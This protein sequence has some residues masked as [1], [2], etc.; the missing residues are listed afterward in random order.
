MEKRQIAFVQ[1]MEKSFCPT[2][3]K[4]EGLGIHWCKALTE[5]IFDATGVVQSILPPGAVFFERVS[6]AGPTEVVV[7]LFSKG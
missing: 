7:F 6:V 5:T 2:L 4:R 3:S 1:N